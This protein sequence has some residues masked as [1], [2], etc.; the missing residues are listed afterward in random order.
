MTR[1]TLPGRSTIAEIL[2]LRQREAQRWQAF[3]DARNDGEK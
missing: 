2:E 3:L 1:E